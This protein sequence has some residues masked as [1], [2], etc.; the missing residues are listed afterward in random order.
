ME[1]VYLFVG[2][3]IFALCGIVLILY[4]NRQYDKKNSK[5]KQCK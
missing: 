5:G 3:S 4:Q 2:L 1:A